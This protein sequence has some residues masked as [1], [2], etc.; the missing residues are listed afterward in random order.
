LI[1]N[2]K[3][4]KALFVHIEGYTRISNAPDGLPPLDVLYQVTTFI[5]AA[6][7]PLSLLVLGAHTIRIPAAV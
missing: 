5:G 6:A 2:V 4:L 1:A 3:P 7:V